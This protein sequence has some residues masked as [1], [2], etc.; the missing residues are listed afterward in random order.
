MKTLFTAE[1]FSDITLCGVVVPGGV[2][3]VL[4]LFMTGGGQGSSLVLMTVTAV[5]VTSSTQITRPPS[6]SSLSPPTTLQ[7]VAPA[8][9]ALQGGGAV[10]GLGRGRHALYVHPLHLHL[11]LVLHPPVLKPDLDL[12]LRQVQHPRHL[13]PPGSHRVSLCRMSRRD[14]ELTS[15]C[16][17]ICWSGTPSPAPPAG[18]WCRLSW[19]S[20][21]P[22]PGCPAGH[23]HLISAWHSPL[24]A[25]LLTCPRL[26]LVRGAGGLLGEA[27][28]GR[29]LAGPAGLGLPHPGVDGGGL[30]RGGGLRLCLLGLD[31]VSS[32]PVGTVLVVRVSVA[33][34]VGVGVGGVLAE[35]LAVLR[36]GPAPGPARLGRGHH[37]GHQEG[38]HSSLLTGHLATRIR[39]LRWSTTEPVNT[40]SSLDWPASTLDMSGLMEKL[41]TGIIRVNSL[42]KTEGS[43]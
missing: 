2:A 17:D 3:T 25:W 12:S 9:P 22:P 40:S 41:Q 15:V 10:P 30:G 11:L 36:G 13:N 14:W 28:G 23:S 31:L 19:P 6:S 18:C 1:I 21:R 39:H 7:T 42:R 20:W 37:G 16:R 8:W 5:M 34:H 27:A 33:V 26:G 29:Q 32:V 43:W 35:P 38:R 4:L 24:T